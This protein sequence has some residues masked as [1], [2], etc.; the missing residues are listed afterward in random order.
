M[1]SALASIGILFGRLAWK[2]EMALLEWG[3]NWL[4]LL[5]ESL[6]PG[7]EWNSEPPLK[8]GWLGK[9]AQHL[10]LRVRIE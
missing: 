5:A 7:L 1:S 10:A 8:W 2:L 9:E 4:F 6:M 3:K